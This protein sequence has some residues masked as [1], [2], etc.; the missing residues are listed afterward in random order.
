M[1]HNLLGF[2]A[3]AATVSFALSMGGGV[4]DPSGLL[5]SAARAQ[6]AV[7][8]AKEGSNLGNGST[9]GSFGTEN[10]SD[11]GASG[12]KP[13]TTVDRT[14]LGNGSG[15]GNETGTGE[16][17]GPEAKPDV[18]VED[19]GAV[20]DGD[21]LERSLAATAAAP[22]VE[23][24]VSAIPKAS[25]P[26]ITGNGSMTQSIAIDVPAYRS[27]SPK[28][29]LSYDSARK[30]RL[31][32]LYQ[33]FTGFAWGLDGLDVI[34]R[35]S[36]GYGVP[37]YNASDVYLLNGSEL[38]A[39]TTGMV[40]A[41]CATG[42]TH[43]NENEDY[44]RIRFDSAANT[45]TVTAR[46]G[47]VSLFRSV[48]AMANFNPAA[49]TPE[50]DMNQRGRYV[51]ASVTDTNG[52]ATTYKY[53]CPDL[54]M[55]LPERIT[56]N[57]NY[58]TNF[59]YDTRPDFQ[60][61]ANGHFLTWIKHRLK[62][63]VNY[64][65]GQHH[66]AYSL[67]YDQAPLSNTSRLVKV[68]RWGRDVGFDGN[69]NPISGTSKIIRQ[70]AY[71]NYAISYTRK[72][73]TFP[74]TDLK[75][76]DGVNAQQV[77]DLNFDGRDEI[78]GILERQS[79]SLSSPTFGF[80][81]T[82][83]D[84]N[85]VTAKTR[86]GGAFESPAFVAPG[87]FVEGKLTKDVFVTYSTYKEGQGSTQHHRFFPVSSALDL[88]AF[89]TCGAPYICNIAKSESTVAVAD[90]DG[91]GVDTLFGNRGYPAEVL[92]NG[93]QGIIWKNT[94]SHVSNGVWV[95]VGLPGNCASSACSYGDLNGDGV[96]DVVHAPVRGDPYYQSNIFFGTGR[97]FVHMLGSVPMLG[98]PMLRDMDNDGKMDVI[99][100][101]RLNT[102]VNAFRQ[103]NLYG[104]W[105]GASG[106]TLPL[107]SSFNGSAVSGDFNGDGLPDFLAS[108]SQ[109]A[110]SN[111][112]SGH[113]NV[114]RNVTLETGGTVAVDYAPSTRFAN[115]FLPQVLH[116]VTKLTVND[117][118]GGIAQTDYTYAGGL[119]DVKARKFLGFRTITMTK[120]L[121]NGEAQRPV[122]QTTYRQDLAS[123]G[124]PER[125]LSRNGENTASKDVVETYQVNATTRPYWV[126]NVATDTT[127]NETASIKLRTE[128]AI[129]AYGNVTDVKDFGR[130]DVNG[131]EVWTAQR[132]APNTSAYIVSLPRWK[133]VIKGHSGTDYVLSEV[134]HY[135]GAGDAAAPPAKGNLTGHLLYSKRGDADNVWKSVSRNYRYDSRGNRIAAVDGA[136]SRTEWEYDTTYGMFPAK[137]R[138]PRYFATGGNAADTRF[139]TGIGYDLVCGLPSSKTDPNGVA[140]R[141]VF[142]FENV[143]ASFRETEELLK[144]VNWYRSFKGLYRMEVLCL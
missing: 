5:I 66:S 40:S 30:S 64:A 58:Y 76:N 124:L 144:A 139:V 83:F 9:L 96:T 121:A 131:D 75:L 69:A 51:L 26:E 12:A 24:P 28:L 109:T 65:N 113:P 67:S 18:K 59:F 16:E 98:I 29:A 3:L 85:G 126:K 47:T 44:R 27:L 94:I 35:A 17:I 133:A 119:Y 62:S 142:I 143:S 141:F 11:E 4:Q 87:R 92:A 140:E 46:D 110:I 134:L 48:A 112:G 105:L 74:H 101:D 136:G 132:Y 78:Y 99:A 14:R 102:Q 81:L 117:G 13:D 38:V 63:V 70:M 53:T 97:T 1:R 2:A 120:P 79:S 135:D 36:P 49:G 84:G 68:T 80:Q 122:V 8:G 6:E 20:K 82:S 41:S 91:D 116:P 104:L 137:E 128:R 111:I 34:E 42:G 103:L 86:V 114:L 10:R 7:T 37:A 123:Y 57:T 125:T 88:G 90:V 19:P 39:C 71:D 115:T 21:R 127:L 56:Y 108:T 77:D 138:G 130:T 118:R 73:F 55:C 31:G 32:G 33:G 25:V 22:L 107:Y 61:A 43:A 129:D 54:P 95:G 100:S 93:R 52:N 15:S 60:T 45:W 72:T 23:S 106:N 89:A 50:H